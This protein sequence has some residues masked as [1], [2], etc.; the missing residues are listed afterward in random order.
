MMYIA[1]LKVIVIENYKKKSFSQTNIDKQ[2][3]FKLK[4]LVHNVIRKKVKPFI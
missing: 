2:N 3:I 1:L 4:V